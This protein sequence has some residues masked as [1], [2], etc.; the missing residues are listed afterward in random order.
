[1]IKAKL[2]PVNPNAN[3]KD[4]AGACA[5]FTW[6][7]AE[8]DFSW[9]R[10]GKCN[11][12]HEAV[13]R[14]AG[15]PAWRERTALIF[16]KGGDTRPFTYA[17]LEETSARWADLLARQG[18]RRGDVFFIHLPPCPEMAFAMLACARLGVVFCPLYASLGYDELDV[19][20][21]DATPKGILTLPDLA[22]K[23]PTEGLISSATLFFPEGP[24]PGCFRNELVI[25]EHLSTST[26]GRE[27]EWVSRQTPL[28]LL[29]TSG[30]AEPPKGV[31]HTHGDMVGHL[32]TARWVLDLAEG[33]VLWTD[34]DPA[35]VTGTVYGVFAPWLCGA[36]SVMQGNPFSAASWYQTLERH[37][38]EVWYTSPMTLRK[39]MEEGDDLPTRYDFS[40]LRHICAVGEA[41][42]PEMFYWV[43]ENMKRSP[44]DTWWMNETG[45]ICLAQFPSLPLKPGSMGKPIPGVHAAV[46]DEEGNPLPMLTPG[47]LALR[48]PW[49]GMM[50][51]IL[52]DRERYG[53]YFRMEGWFLTGDMV[54]QDEEGYFYHQGR[55][56]DL[57]KV[58][59][60][61]IG[62]YEIERA[63]RQHPAVLDAAVISMGGGSR[64]PRLKA[65]I[66]PAAGFSPSNRLKH[67]IKAFLLGQ[68]SRDL[69]LR[70]VAFLEELP[71]T[72]SGK[73][74]RRVL[75]AME[76]GLPAG[77]PARMKE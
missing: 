45:I 21:R 47:Q 32:M 5:S 55:M 36:A 42:G 53:E 31:V 49:P 7:E 54:L 50:L 73:L 66:T 25:S 46:I 48:P 68:L 1:M 70:D 41:L 65:F 63:L 40:A 43:K 69:P 38:V 15:D 24:S 64:A 72:K 26:S 10:T 62:P 74:L 8:K 57:F 51:E 44:H 34:A 12:A 18:L 37:R 14:R 6:E 28:Y 75:R 17:Q 9:H 60:K 13:G 30:S 20:I 52:G 71:R 39:L 2:D 19:R 33:S 58:G 16:D 77:D 29:Y 56:D 59:E 76:L 4:Y 35:W 61:V 67:E 23:I 3:L 22:E 11:I 27:P